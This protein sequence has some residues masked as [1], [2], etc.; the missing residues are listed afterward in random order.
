MAATPRWKVYTAGGEYVASCRY[1]TD[2][3]VLVSAYSTG[4]TIRDGHRVKDIVW[5][6]G[7]EEF[8]AGESWDTVAEVVFGRVRK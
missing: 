1:P 6:E 7:K 8:A 2:A 3:A 5:N 4:A